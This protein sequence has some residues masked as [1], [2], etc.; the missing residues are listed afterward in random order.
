MKKWSD[1]WLNKLNYRVGWFDYS[2]VRNHELRVKENNTWRTDTILY[3]N[4]PLMGVNKPCIIRINL[5]SMS[6]WDEHHY[7]R[8]HHIVHDDIWQF[9]Y[10]G[11]FVFS[12]FSL[13]QTCVNNEPPTSGDVEITKKCW[14][15]RIMWSSCDHHGIL[16]GSS[17]TSFWHLIW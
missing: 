7:M 2:I 17:V 5:E 14:V 15:S 3:E 6:S 11:L 1:I 4:Q 9:R 12:G 8:L 16:D 10:S 13:Q